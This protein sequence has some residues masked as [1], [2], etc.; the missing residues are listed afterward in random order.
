MSS[1]QNND[2]APEGLKD[3]HVNVNR[4]KNKGKSGSKSTLNLAKVSI[5]FY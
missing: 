1:R 3:K 2:E 5:V 4:K